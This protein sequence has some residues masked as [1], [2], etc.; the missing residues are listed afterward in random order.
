MAFTNISEDSI[1]N[2]V[3]KLTTKIENLNLQ[4]LKSV[5]D[6]HINT[7][8]IRCKKICVLDLKS[9]SITDDS[10]TNIIENLRCT[11]EEINVGNTYVRNSARIINE[12]SLPNLV[13]FNNW[14]FS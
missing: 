12:G 4:E 10:L 13:S 6:G 9:T 5:N 2:L 14:S 7:L 11:L 8:V 3:S 1:D